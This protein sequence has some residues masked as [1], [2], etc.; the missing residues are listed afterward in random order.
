MKELLPYQEDKVVRKEEELKLR[1]NAGLRNVG[2]GCEITGLPPR[3][4]LEK[5]I[6][7]IT[8]T[9]LETSTSEVQLGNAGDGLLSVE[10]KSDKPWLQVEPTHTTGNSVRLTVKT[11]GTK[12]TRGEREASIVLTDSTA[13]IQVRVPIAVRQT[14]TM[15]QSVMGWITL[16]VL[17]V[18][19]LVVWYVAGSLLPMGLVSQVSA[20]DM[21]LLALLV[22][23]LA[24][25]LMSTFDVGH[26]DYNLAPIVSFGALVH[27]AMAYLV[28]RTVIAAGG[29]AS[30]LGALFLPLAGYTVVFYALKH[31]YDAWFFRTPKQPK[32][33]QR[34]RGNAWPPE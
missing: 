29:Q 8:V 30:I 23:F 7:P 31:L 10:A 33:S 19:I 34:N 20:R 16:S 17:S 32:D 2:I 12:V 25:M 28:L 4:V 24:F 3:M 27:F 21:V 14:F 15:T 13:G 26:Y 1:T 11:T 18:A 9:F 5:E 6:K 22:G